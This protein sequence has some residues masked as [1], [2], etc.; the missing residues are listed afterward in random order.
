MLPRLLKSVADR[1]VILSGTVALAVALLVGM[2]VNSYAGLLIVCAAI[3]VGY[4][5][6]LTP[7][8]RILRRSASPED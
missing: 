7:S 8:R 4:S 2:A 1:P 3:G 6:V 5:L